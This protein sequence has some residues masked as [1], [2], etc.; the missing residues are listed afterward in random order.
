M[1]FPEAGV[2]DYVFTNATAWSPPES[3]LPPPGTIEI[4]IEDYSPA[5]V[6]AVLGKRAA[7]Q[8]P[9]ELLGEAHAP[10][11]SEHVVRSR[12]QS[13]LLA[14]RPAAE[15]TYRYVFQGNRNVQTELVTRQNGEIVSIVMDSD[16]SLQ[17][18]AAAALRTIAGHWQWLTRATAVRTPTVPAPRQFVPAPGI[19][20][21]GQWIASGFV[22][23]DSG[24]VADAHIDQPEVRAWDFTRDCVTGQH[25]RVELT[26]E[27][28]GADPSTGPVTQ[29]VGNA[30]WFQVRFPVVHALCARRPTGPTLRETIRV[31]LGFGWV[32]AKHL[33]LVGDDTETILGCGSPVPAVLADHWTARRVPA[34]SSI[35]TLTIDPR[36]ASSAGAFRVAAGRVCSA[37]TGRA[38]RV[39]RGLGDALHLLATSKSP[40]AR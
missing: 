27:L 25:C 32:S 40:E 11:G 2:I 34:P 8:N 3:V 1:S 6:P 23:A 28:V 33:A 14:G 13:L 30:G 31:T 39:A 7:N 9:L 16:P 35:P 19:L 12:G 24:D 5:A 20:P 4:Q 36:H 26:R 15:E 29:E 38:A 37:L 21:S 17:A 18:R 22:G 10:R